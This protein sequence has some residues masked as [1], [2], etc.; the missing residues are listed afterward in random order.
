[1]FQRWPLIA[2]MAGLLFFGA[3][4]PDDGTGPGGGGGGG[5][6]GSETRLPELDG[7]PATNA[8][9]RLLYFVSTAEDGP[10]LYSVN[11]ANP[12]AAPTYVDP[13]LNI[14][15]P[16]AHAVHLGDRQAGGT[17]RD[18]HAGGVFYSTY[19]QVELGNGMSQDTFSG[20]QYLVSAEPSEAN[21]P[22]RRIGDTKMAASMLRDMGGIFA[23]GLDAL[24]DSSYAPNAPSFD[25]GENIRIDFNLGEDDPPLIAP[26]GTFVISFLGEG[27]N[28]HEHWLHRADSDGALR[29]YNRD[30]SDSEPL[31][32]DETN[33][34]I[35]GAHIF[36]KHI[37]Y[38]TESESIAVIAFEDDEADG[39]LKGAL[40]V[41]TRPD[42]SNPGGRAKRILNSEGEA[43]VVSV[44]MIVFGRAA[45]AEPFLF[46]HD[47]AI[48]FASG[49][50]MFSDIWT[51]LT[52]LDRDGWSEFNHRDALI[53][54]GKTPGMA[55]LD[56]HLPSVFISL[57]DGRVFWA[58]GGVPEIITPTAGPW[59]TWHREAID[60][61][62]PE[63]TT[64]LSSA[65][66][67]IFYNYNG[68]PDGATAVNVN[69]KEVISFPGSTWL[70]ASHD[71][72]G[73]LAGSVLQTN[74]SE[75]F[76]HHRDGELRAL[77]AS[78]PDKGYVILG[79]LP[80]G[81]EELNI[82]GLG[83][84]PHRLFQ[85]V[86]GDESVEVLFADTSRK[87][88]LI[89]VMNAPARGWKR[90]TGVTIGDTELT[91]DVQPRLTQP[92][93]GF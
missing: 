90:P 79:A 69:S 72:T 93:A 77:E 66:D 59:E 16:F 35:V 62:R 23:F 70:G 39:E 48:Y 29:F 56:S 26:K 88:S 3:C 87:N 9:D 49:P 64:I 92:V 80:G 17:L 47:E 36:T 5:G 13:E 27:V 74:I 7:I 58:P 40:Y 54:D 46:Q 57:K 20:Q 45:P 12:E 2:G 10:G 6:G 81:T 86:H 28:T 21:T 63:N 75:V 25:L 76:L 84:G 91:S 60:A 4:G 37:A 11:P 41:V 85:L 15:Y 43:Y 52:R 33:A 51:T 82:A 68:S 30:L 18:F 55:L 61:P 32:D 53:A 42:E 22:P 38:L 83:R 31:L 24:E 65:N 34:P 8:V 50:S 19:F 89:P 14:I 78:A 71:G 67:W 73:A 44:G 1:M